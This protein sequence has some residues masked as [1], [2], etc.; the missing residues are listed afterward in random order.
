MAD[1]NE[2]NDLFQ[3]LGSVI[4][5]GTN[6]E[7]ELNGAK[8]T[9]VKENGD[10]TIKV[11]KD[12]KFDDSEVVKVVNNFKDNVKLIDDCLFVEIN[13]EAGEEIDIKEF[14]K[15]LNQEHFDKDSAI[16]VINMIDVFSEITRSHLQKEVERLVDLYERF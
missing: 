5:E 6:K 10:T 4:P 16:K 14:D 8:V 13:E 15:L 11:I 9:L 1:L 12:E 3:I 7:F 2:I